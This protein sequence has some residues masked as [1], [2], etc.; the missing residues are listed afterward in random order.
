[1]NA[2]PKP[3]AYALPAGLPGMPVGSLVR[4]SATGREG[5]LRDVL[6]YQPIDVLPGPDA[7]PARRLVFLRPVGGGLEWA[8]EPEQV[9][10]AGCDHPGED[11]D[12]ASL[13]SANRR[14]D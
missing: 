12:A 14:A 6:L 3:N 13:G 11:P 4:D 5:T 7:R 1:M 8:T 10:P 9:V 2:P